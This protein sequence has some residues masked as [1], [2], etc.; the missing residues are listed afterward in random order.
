MLYMAS[1]KCANIDQLLFSV[2]QSPIMT[3]HELMMTN[4]CATDEADSSQLLI[5][6]SPKV[7]TKGLKQ[8]RCLSGPKLL[9]AL[10]NTC[11]LHVPKLEFQ[12]TAKQFVLICPKC[13]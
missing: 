11:R 8:R 2:M 5:D 12:F 1:Q 4:D 3:H 10:L 13:E 6:V 9:C 7:A